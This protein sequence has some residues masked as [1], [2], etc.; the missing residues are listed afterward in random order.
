MSMSFLVVSQSFVTSFCTT[1][2]KVLPRIWKIF[3]CVMN[4]YEFM[5]KYKEATFKIEFFKTSK[6]P[7]KPSVDIS[8]L[9]LSPFH[10]QVH[11]NFFIVFVDDSFDFSVF[12]SLCK[13]RLWSHCATFAFGLF[14]FQLFIPICA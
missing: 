6:K 4:F 3:C 1:F 10:P 5:C 14:F 9:V 12:C 7:L 11:N 8:S 13:L 2:F